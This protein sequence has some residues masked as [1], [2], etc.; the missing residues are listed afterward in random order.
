VSRQAKVPAAI[1][2]SLRVGEVECFTL[3]AN[4]IILSATTNT[5]PGSIIHLMA[6][7]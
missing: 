5:S 4:S 1:S 7:G 3:G 6:D 2:A